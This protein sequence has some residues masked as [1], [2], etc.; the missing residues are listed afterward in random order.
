MRK[1]T[2]GPNPIPRI[3]AIDGRI[4]CGDAG[5]RKSEGAPYR[6]VYTL[7]D[8]ERKYTSVTLVQS[9]ALQ[10]YVYGGLLSWNNR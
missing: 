6:I 2:E 4:R 7:G 10:F 1:G 8:T 9:D 5:P 3:P